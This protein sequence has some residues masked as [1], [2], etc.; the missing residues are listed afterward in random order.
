M[1]RIRERAVLAGLGLGLGWALG[2]G[3]AWACSTWYQP[4]EIQADPGDG[5]P[6]GAPEMAVDDIRRAQAPERSGCGSVYATSCDDI[7]RIT[8][9][10][11]PPADGEELGYDFELVAGE[12]PENFSLPSGP[13]SARDGNIYLS[14]S[15]QEHYGAFSFEL[16]VHALDRAGN[17]SLEATRVE[18]RSGGSDD[19]CSTHGAGRDL[20]GL[21]LLG[22]V[23]WNLKQRGR[24]VLVQGPNRLGG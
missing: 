10:V 14:W 23:L 1:T 12:L 3:G 15:E 2:V 22:L 11:T 18:L 5:T 8:L 6:P 19:G 21:V 24:F 13:L 4:F 7:A 20:G 16:A 17:R 9:A